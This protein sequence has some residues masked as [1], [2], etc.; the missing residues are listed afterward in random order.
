MSKEEMEDMEIVKDEDSCLLL[1]WV[2]ETLQNEVKKEEG[3]FLSA[4]LVTL[5]ASLLGNMVTGKGIIRPGYGFR[6]KGIIR[7]VYGSNRSSMK[8]F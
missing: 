3:E 8:N 2:S 4:L 5:G 1:K 7:A 6:G